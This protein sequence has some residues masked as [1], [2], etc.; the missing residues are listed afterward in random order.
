MFEFH[1]GIVTMSPEA[2]GIPEFAALKRRKSFE[3]IIAYLFFVYGK[4]SPYANLFEYD[5]KLIVS[6]DRLGDPQEYKRIE[7]QKGVTQAVEK[8]LKLQLTPKEQ[9]L[10]GVKR[11][12]EEYLKFWDS[13]HID[14]ENYKI[15]SD[16]LDGANKLLKLQKEI[17]L[18]VNEEATETKIVGGG[19]ANLFE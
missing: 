9:L 19:K 16:S 1:N 8:Y 12:I 15:V 11:K 10:A 6:T 14:E 4:K 13:T 5:R 2:E 3:K 17:E 18:Q 7:E